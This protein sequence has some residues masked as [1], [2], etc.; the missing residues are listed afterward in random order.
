M[1]NNKTIKLA[2]INMLQ[3]VA[4]KLGSLCNELVF[5][6]GC[7]TALFINDENTPDVRYTFDVDCIVEA[8]SLNDYHR[9]EK[10]LQNIGFKQSLHEE[11][12]CRWR[13]EDAILDLMPTDKK[14]LG[15][16]NHWYR[17]NARD[18]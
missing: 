1:Q 8:T 14:I 16:G 2:N 13:Y 9:L 5:L 4:D 6:G 17:E 11:T 12:I 15:F 3:F 18:R 10:K 7:T